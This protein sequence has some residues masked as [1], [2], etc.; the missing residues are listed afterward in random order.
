MW[1]V[2]NAL[3]KQ[4]TKSEKRKERRFYLAQLTAL[5]RARQVIRYDRHWALKRGHPFPGQPRHYAGLKNCI[6][7]SEALLQSPPT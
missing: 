7:I 2:L 4:P 6:R 1:K 5:I 3:T